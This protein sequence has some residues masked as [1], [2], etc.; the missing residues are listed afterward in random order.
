MADG[1]KVDVVVVGGGVAGLAAA[2]VWRHHRSFFQLGGG[3]HTLARAALK[4]I[5]PTQPKNTTDMKLCPP[6]MAARTLT[7]C[8]YMHVALNGI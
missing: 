4:C 3:P 7:A 1:E 2:A 5:G 6:G 8:I